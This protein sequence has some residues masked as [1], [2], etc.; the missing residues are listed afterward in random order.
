[1]AK[2]N[3]PAPAPLATFTGCIVG[4]AA[5]LK[6]VRRALPL[7][8]KSPV[9]PALSNFLV[10]CKDG[11]LTLTA[12]DMEK[13]LI[14]APLRVESMGDWSICIPAD[15]LATTL[16]TLPDQPVRLVVDL[17]TFAVE[18]QAGK[19]RFRVS[20]EVAT[21]F[22]KTPPPNGPER[23]M[24]LPAPLLGRA[25]S[26]VAPSMLNDV[27]RPAMHGLYLH[28]EGESLTA[29][30]TNG[31]Q[32]ARVTMAL[33]NADLPAVACIIPRGAVPALIVLLEDAEWATVLIDRLNVRVTVESGEY[34]ARLV[35]DR[36]P[37]YPNVIPMRN[38]NELT[39]D[40]AVL[41]SA[42]RQ[43]A[44]Y[45]NKS[46]NQVRIGL[47]P[48][49]DLSL[50]AEDLDFSNEA[51][52]ELAGAAYEGESM[53]IGFSARYLSTMVALLPDG[54]IRVQ[55]STPNRAALL[56]P[57]TQ[58]AGFDVL[59]LLMPVMVNAYVSE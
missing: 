35:D 12:S 33:P 55:M 24:V 29:V 28:G 43:V 6:V 20:G 9:V 34:I 45:A 26:T 18:L 50:T 44:A 4:S 47:E 59:L 58:E 13:T 30:A 5:L 27:L 22:P 52:V 19:S 39:I 10:T 40:R 23:R 42:V 21:A 48:T 37:D 56:L 7:V 14:T 25:L 32:L 31:Y 1:M 16:G 53:M 46:T 49:G 36:Y 8:P 11:G 3:A 57:E 41:A 54:P 15:M 17:D 2:K 51:S 38:P